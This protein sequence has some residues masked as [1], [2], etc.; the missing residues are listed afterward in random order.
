M[1]KNKAQSILEYTI[2]IIIA[3][4]AIFTMQ[5]YFTRGVQGRIRS[6]ADELSGSLM[7]S[8][9]KTTGDA[10]IE[11]TITEEMKTSTEKT[12][13]EEKSVTENTFNLDQKTNRTES[14]SSLP[15][16]PGADKSE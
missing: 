4:I 7:Y 8:P 16:E 11:R 15:V 10:K 1:E 12:T 14:V 13:T 2:L 6:G 3:V 5:I 9:G